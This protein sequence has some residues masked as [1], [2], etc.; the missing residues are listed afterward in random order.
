MFIKKNDHMTILL[1][2][3]SSGTTFQIYYSNSLYTCITQKWN[4]YQKLLQEAKISEH[5]N[6]DQYRHILPYPAVSYYKNVI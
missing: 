6:H 2:I 4:A 1:P 5:A 3:L